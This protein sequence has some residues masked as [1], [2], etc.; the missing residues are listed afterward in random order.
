VRCDG[1]PGAGDDDGLAGF[2]SGLD[3]ELLC[4]SGRG[5]TGGGVGDGD[6]RVS[7]C[8][9]A[10]TCPCPPRC[11][12]ADTLASD[13]ESDGVMGTSAGDIP[14]DNDGLN[15][16]DMGICAGEANGAGFGKG[17]TSSSGSGIASSPVVYARRASRCGCC[18]P[19]FVR[20]AGSLARRTS[21]GRGGALPPSLAA[22]GGE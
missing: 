1:G 22:A 17:S 3:T 7:T 8:P 16:G 11:A 10:G 18:V 2:R 14:G 4:S 12:C 9:C 21:I 15:A 13:G 20:A 5:G 6:A 19:T